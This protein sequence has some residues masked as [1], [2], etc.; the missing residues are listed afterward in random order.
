MFNLNQ[1]KLHEVDFNS[2][3]DFS[4][5]FLYQKNSHDDRWV[6]KY[7]HAVDIE[8]LLHILHSTFLNYNHNHPSILP[9]HGYFLEAA[10]PRGYHLYTKMPRMKE[11]L[12][13]LFAK[14]LQANTI[15]PEE[16][17][18]KYFYSLV[19]GLEHLHLKK[20]PHKNIK[21]SNILFDKNGNI[22]LADII[23]REEVSTTFNF[24]LDTATSYYAA[25]DIFLN[26]DT[27]TLNKKSYYLGDIWSLGIIIA[28]LCLLEPAMM[29]K[30][31]T[32]DHK[33]YI[34]KRL[35]QVEE[36]YNKKLRE[37]ISLL[38]E[39]DI[40]KRKNAT[41][42]RRLMEEQYREIVSQISSFK[43]PEV[44][45]SKLELGKFNRGLGKVD[46]E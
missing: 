7:K 3:G 8:K 23:A 10:Q 35:N 42:I 15:I 24:S 16:T 19:C 38:L 12:R 4:N 40:E 27:K 20:I 29:S 45:F 5:L 9:V 28:E 13:D 22:K 1:S 17:I 31:D 18:I 41:D 33:E 37:L 39:V 36:K 26:R 44:P 34:K 2:L 14:H 46:Y 32:Y 6:V 43:E 21:P 30:M 11:N 25:P